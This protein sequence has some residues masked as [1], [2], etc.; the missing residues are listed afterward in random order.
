MIVA[1]TLYAATIER[2]AE[3]ATLRAMGASNAYLN[4]IVLKQALIGG[5]LGYLLGLAAAFA[6]VRAAA[7]STI[8]LILPWQLALGVG[9]VTVLMCAGASLVAIRKIKSID[10][11]MVFR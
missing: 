4:S 2:L 5:A 6:L 9:L 7:N 8:S 10:P 3:F 11:T 1:Q